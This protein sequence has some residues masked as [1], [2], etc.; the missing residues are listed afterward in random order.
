MSTTAS[1]IYAIVNLKSGKVY[2]GSASNMSMRMSRHRR[3]LASGMHSNHLLQSDWNALHDPTLWMFTILQLTVN[4]QEVEQRW[5]D[6]YDSSNPEKGYNLHS[7]P[8]TMTSTSR[9]RVSFVA[10]SSVGGNKK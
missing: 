10:R 5:V 4:L 8:R 6:F 9:K 1:G 2:I 7:R 3:D